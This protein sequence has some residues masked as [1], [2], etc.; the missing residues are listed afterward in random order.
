MPTASMFHD[1]F[2]L[3]NTPTFFA[4]IL[5]ES[6]TE[7]VTLERCEAALE[8]LFRRAKETPEVPPQDL[9]A[10]LRRHIADLEIARLIEPADGVAWRLTARGRAALDAHPDGL[11]RTDLAA[12]PEYAS[13][14]QTI[15][16]SKNDMD[17]RTASY[18]EGYFAQGEG[19][20]FAANPYT[21]N[22]ID[23]LSWEN[24]W[25]E[26]QEDEQRG[27][28]TSEAGRISG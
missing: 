6:R 26:A 5:Q 4:V 13:H 17:P 1:D 7:A 12:Y 19:Q 27:A 14:L 8:E 25:M 2:P 24:G 15:S 23:H 10:R 22:T 21:P 16:R 3:L 9:R 18:D 28:Q 11:D 20:T